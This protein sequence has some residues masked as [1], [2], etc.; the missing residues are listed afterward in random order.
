[1]GVAR[2]VR[3][4]SEFTVYA[5][6]TEDYLNS[7]AAFDSDVEFSLNLFLR[8]EYGVDLTGDRNTSY[9]GEQFNPQELI[10]TYDSETGKYVKLGEDLL[11][12]N[13]F[14]DTLQRGM[15][16]FIPSLDKNGQL[17]FSNPKILKVAQYK[18]E[19]QLFIMGDRQLRHAEAELEHVQKPTFWQRFADG[20]LKIFGSRNAA[21]EAYEKLQAMMGQTLTLMH[22]DHEKIKSFEMERQEQEQ[23]AVQETEELGNQLEEVRQM[24]QE[25][26][27]DILDLPEYT[28][29]AQNLIK[30]N[31]SAEEFYQLLEQLEKEGSKKLE[32]I[33]EDYKI[34]HDA[35]VAVALGN[36]ARDLRSKADQA[37]NRESFLLENRESFLLLINNIE[38]QVREFDL[39]PLNDLYTRD[40]NSE[41]LPAITVREKMLNT[42]GLLDSDARNIY[43]EYLTQIKQEGETQER[44]EMP[45]IEEIPV[46]EKRPPV[47]G[48]SL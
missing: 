24:Q 38:K 26:G 46:E 44:E 17:D 35:V 4:T 45:K 40:M 28:R 20:F 5:Q 21:C 16:Y 12:S 7:H 27:V 42:L 39:S 41:S 14:M 31:M 32:E 22:N 43:Q 25:R 8:S 34:N 18:G 10:Y 6:S 2:E 9:K 30:R 36:P 37:E 15:P 47:E 13:Y 11:Q 29:Q 33:A 19:N 1:M 3:T 48:K 23:Q